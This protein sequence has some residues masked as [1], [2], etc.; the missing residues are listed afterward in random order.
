M[1]KKV[2][3]ENF[4]ILLKFKNKEW[5]LWRKVLDSELVLIGVLKG[6]GLSLIKRVKSIL[7]RGNI[8][9][10][11]KERCLLKLNIVNC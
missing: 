3:E 10:K 1:Y 8:I 9:N 2:V 6:I 5:R 4:L 11:G 7:G